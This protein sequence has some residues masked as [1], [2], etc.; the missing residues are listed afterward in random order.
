[1]MLKLW[2]NEEDPQ[3]ELRVFRIFYGF[4]VLWFK[5]GVRFNGQVMDYC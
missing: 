4:M 5:N 1:M 3:S 2:S